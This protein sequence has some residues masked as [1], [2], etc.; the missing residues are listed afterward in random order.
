MRYL[1]CADFGTHTHTQH[2]EREGGRE[3]PLPW[4][5]LACMKKCSLLPFTPISLLMRLLS[6][7]TAPKCVGMVSKLCPWVVSYTKFSRKVEFQ[8]S[9]KK[10][11]SRVEVA[12]T[13]VS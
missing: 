3:R 7:V 2:G 12:G 4:G 9:L 11:I 8:C 5:F 13:N 6:F 10:Y 1:G